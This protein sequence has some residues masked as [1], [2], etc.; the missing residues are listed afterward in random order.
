M[1]DLQPAKLLLAS[2]TVITDSQG[3]LRAISTALTTAAG[4]AR[5]T[6]RAVESKSFVGKGLRSCW[7]LAISKHAVNAVHGETAQLG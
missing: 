7:T 6:V 3:R 5:L 4:A 1:R 2:S